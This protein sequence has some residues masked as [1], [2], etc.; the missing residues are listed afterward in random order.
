MT[1]TPEKVI[2]G[3]K[4][5]SRT[6]RYPVNTN[7]SLSKELK[8]SSGLQFRY[9]TVQVYI[10]F[11]KRPGLRIEATTVTVSYC[12]VEVLVP[13]V[14]FSIILLYFGRNIRT[15]TIEYRYLNQSISTPLIFILSTVFASLLIVMLRLWLG[16]LKNYEATVTKS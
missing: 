7:Y 10:F 3:Q 5:Q 14:L 15:S 12:T 11:K 16:I 9:R 2:T 6:V 4:C 8:I 1:V 13:I